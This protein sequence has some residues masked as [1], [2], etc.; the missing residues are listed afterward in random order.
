MQ[1]WC[2][3]MFMADLAEKDLEDIGDYIAYELKNPFAAENTVSGIRVH[4]NNLAYFPER[5]GFTKLIQK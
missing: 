1:E 3:V 4:I 2:Q 5:N